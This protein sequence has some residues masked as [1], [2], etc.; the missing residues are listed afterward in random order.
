MR[1]KK[2][3]N[4]FSK[5]TDL[6]ELP[7]TAAVSPAK[8]GY[9]YFLSY[10]HI[11]SKEIQYFVDKL[12]TVNNSASIFYDK[13]RLYTAALREVTPVVDRVGSGDAFMGGLIYGLLNKEFDPQHTINFAVAA[14]CLK[15]T[16]SGDF[17]LATLDEVEEMVKGNA[18]GIVSR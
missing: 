3:K 6:L 11:H 14:C 15:H 5:K 4:T 10:A 12:K 18:S 17:N 13:D 8:K 1:W 2:I 7:E 9:D 16:I